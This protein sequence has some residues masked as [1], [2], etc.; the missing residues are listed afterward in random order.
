MKN[1]RN[2]GHL[3]RLQAA[4]DAVFIH[5]AAAVGQAAVTAVQFCV[6]HVDITTAIHQQ[7]FPFTDVA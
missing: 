7:V 1:K 4:G 5:T 6:R 3:V 2:S